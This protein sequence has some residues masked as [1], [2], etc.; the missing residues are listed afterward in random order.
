MLKRK[1][2]DD[3]IEESGSKR[4]AIDLSLSSPLSKGSLD[5]V[6]LPNAEITSRAQPATDT[7]LA[8]SANA[9]PESA[10]PAASV[11]SA[12]AVEEGK[13]SEVASEKPII[14]SSHK[15]NVDP[16]TFIHI[17]L[18]VSLSDAVT[19]I[20][21]GGKTIA[22]IRE[23]TGVRL[24][25]SD[26]YP[27]I[28]ERI[29]NIKGS[30]EHV[31]KVL[32]PDRLMGS[33]I[34]KKGSRFREIEEASAAKLRAAESL[35]LPSTDRVLY[36][37][38][39]ADALH[40]ALYYI[41]TTYI[42]HQE[43]LTTRP[44]FYNPAYALQQQQQQRYSG[45]GD[46]PGYPPH[47]Q[48]SYN[49][50]HSHQNYNSNNSYYR[51]PSSNYH[52]GPGGPGGPPMPPRDY[53]GH[54]LNYDSRQ[55]NVQSYNTGIL[56]YGEKVHLGNG[57]GPKVNMSANP[58]LNQAHQAAKNA[59]R[60]QELTQDVMIPNNFVGTVIGKGGSKIKEIRHVS[61]AKVR[62]LDPI[63]DS[64]E[65]L[66]QITGIPEANEMA[67]YMIHTVIETEKMRSASSR[68]TASNV[69]TGSR[70]DSITGNSNTEPPAF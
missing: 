45:Y 62:V 1:N 5:P 10:E 59:A 50:Y 68:P 7:D 22:S 48:P 46:G 40:I 4:A 53:G 13:S 15:L 42:S 30:A 60:G 14:V 21:K 54:N 25:V 29:V 43:Y 24:K 36:V 34:G 44:I 12:D 47:G 2:S 57:A 56:R 39:V 51:G 52:N 33:M 18:L 58:S 17:R 41:C 19:I 32:I 65:R 69:D 31:S 67:I 8:E 63:P 23:A 28:F 16:S 66:I 64:E 49:N 20:G 26:H 37:H 9:D 70:Y 61:K 11:T 38:G 3:D 35:L 55:H 27:G 6:S